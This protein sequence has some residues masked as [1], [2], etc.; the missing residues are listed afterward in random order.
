MTAGGMSCT[1]VS[2]SAAGS[3]DPVYAAADGTVTDAGHN[4]ARGN[5]ITVSHP[6]GLSTIYMHL[7]KIEAEKGDSVKQGEKIAEM[8]STGRSTG[9]F[10]FSSREERSYG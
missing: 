1:K 4:S 9:P 7:S 3:G 10:A 6:S 5:Y 2:I 8:G